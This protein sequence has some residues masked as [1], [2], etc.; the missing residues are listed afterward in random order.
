MSTRINDY[1]TKQISIERKVVTFRALSRQFNIHVNAAKN[2]LAAYHAASKGTTEA[3]HATYLLTGEVASSKIPHGF[4][5]QGKDGMDVDM[6][7]VEDH[8]KEQDGDTVP[9]TKVLL[10]G[11]NDLE[12][13]K[14]QY[15]RIF[16]QHVY[17]LSPSALV[18]AGLICGPL[19]KVYEADAKISLESS[20]LLGRI[21][22]SQVHT[23]KPMP[24]VASSSKAKATITEKQT[25]TSAKESK[26]KTETQADTKPK[27]EKPATQKIK[28]AGTLDWSKARPKQK[29]E[30]RVKVIEEVQK[31][32]KGKVKWQQKEKEE[33][34]EEVHEK[35]AKETVANSKGKQSSASKAKKGAIRTSPPEVDSLTKTE[36]KR[37]TKRKSVLPTMSDSEEETPPSRSILAING[38][39]LKKSVILSDEDDEES[40]TS[41]QSTHSRANARAKSLSRE[42]TAPEVEMS[43]R[44]M[45]DIDDDEVIKASHP[46]Q[47]SQP[48]LEETQNDDTEVMSDP[49]PV[50]I[51]TK[52]RKKKEKKVIPVGRNG[53]KK[54][55]VMKSRTSVDNRGYIATEDYS[56]YESIDE[57]EESDTP[58]KPKPKGKTTKE[59]TR[60]SK[61]PRD[62]DGL[63]SRRSTGSSKGGG[64][65][66][67]MKFFGKPR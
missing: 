28:P 3:A 10:V 24:P 52:P 50:P 19:E 54:R 23:G 61:V 4:S 53:L 46:G 39:R 56:S 43:L 45:M 51:K 5:T 12:S 14:S 26:A 59:S 35:T 37:G 60:Q 16:S 44:A 11:E 66:N 58:A 47:E 27:E 49:E 8:D 33:R 31:D 67:L 38:T 25:L 65:G 41:R 9:I 13:A 2:E 32:D 42:S 18:D 57:G 40:Q 21:V 20:V 6:D 1:L 55:R 62:S 48:E 15:I 34:D 22:G 7:A 63:K 64:Q 30:A 29:D 36:S 17:S